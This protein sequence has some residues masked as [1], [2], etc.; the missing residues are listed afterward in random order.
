VRATSASQPPLLLCL[1][2]IH[3]LCW[4]GLAHRAY[5]SR[6]L[7]PTS[8]LNLTP[9]LILIRTLNFITT[10]NVALSLTLHG[11][12]R[13]GVTYTTPDPGTLMNHGGYST[14]DTH[15]ACL[16]AVNGGNQFSVNQTVYHTQARVAA[17]RHA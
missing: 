16:I 5:G 4:I 7:T 2:T 11:W 9:T 1:S 3:V 8:K 14:D 6:T 15:I 10:L 17:A 12:G 13:A